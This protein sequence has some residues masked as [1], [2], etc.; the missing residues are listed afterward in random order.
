MS[1][2][3][4]TPISPNAPETTAVHE[5]V[6]HYYGQELQTSAD[7][8]T[9]ACCDPSAM[10]EWLKPLLANVNPTV[11]AKYYGCGLVAPQLLNGA[12]VLDLGCG[13]GRDVYVLAQMVGAQGRVVGVDMTAE[14]LSVAQ[15][16]QDWH[17]ERFGFEN[18]QF[19]QGYIEQ[20][21]DLPVEKESLDVVV[22]NC[23]INLA[24][25]KAAVLRG[26]YGLLNQGGEM[27][28]SDVYV[29]RRLPTHLQE[30]PELY[31]ECLSG[32][33][34]WNDFLHMAR[35]A[36]FADPRL[37]ESR[38]LEITEPRIAAKLGPA[39]FYSATYRLFKLDALESD[40]EDYGQA[41]I[42]KGTMPQHPH[43]FALDAH[44]Y[45][46]TGKVFSVCG[47]TW[48]MLHDTRFAPHFEFIG[49]FG[50]HY[51]I[52]E[53]CG[54]AVPFVEAGEALACC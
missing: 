9:S 20:L 45:I 51:G 4:D 17:T 22:S 52:F 54:K 38:P 1:L 28:F 30:D 8:K 19:V 16:H 24:T 46:E 50:I 26:A 14:Q 49:N 37:V 25:D 7:L 29:D 32:A 21:D 40:C 41:V 15:T 42:Y 27:Y 31:G 36:G 47:N 18:T 2:S 13:S 11:L 53:G 33:L 12:H 23:V 5:Q 44:H 35:E 34:Y 39:R 43:A 48:R 3:T 6:Q 10:P